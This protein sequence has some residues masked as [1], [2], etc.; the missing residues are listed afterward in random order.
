MASGDTGYMFCRDSRILRQSISSAG[1]AGSVVILH[2]YVVLSLSSAKIIHP[3][4]ELSN[5][6]L[7]RRRSPRSGC[8]IPTMQIGFHMLPYLVSHILNA[9]ACRIWHDPAVEDLYVLDKPFT[10]K[11][12]M[13]CT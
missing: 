6:M 11:Q 4:H 3:P 9:R 10:D 8:I 7:N 2:N 5:S 13:I 1:V 12:H